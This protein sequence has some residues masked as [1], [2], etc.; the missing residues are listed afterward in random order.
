MEREEYHRL[1]GVILDAAIAVH[2][3]MG[4]GLLEAVYH[5]CLMKELDLRGIVFKSNLVVPLVYKGFELNKEYV[6]DLLI[7][8]EIVVELKAVEVILPVHEAQIISYL[9]LAKKKLGLLINFNVPLL[10]NGYR[11]YVNG[12]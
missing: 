5:H 9:K 4:P 7:E 1:S 3:E 8:G 12:Y 10:K 6:M 11:R 2:R